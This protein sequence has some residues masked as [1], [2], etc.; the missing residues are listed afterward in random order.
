MIP[1]TPRGIRIL[2]TRSPFGLLLIEVTSPTGSGSPA[3]SLRL[4]AIPS[5]TLS[6]MV[7]RSTIAADRPCASAPSRSLLFA[8]LMRSPP[9]RSPS[10]I[11]RRALSLTL[12]PR[13]ASSSE[14]ERAD[15]ATFKTVDSIDIVDTFPVIKLIRSVVEGFSPRKGRTLK[16]S[17]TCLMHHLGLNLTS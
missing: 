9:L 11:R 13:D 12:E 3:T 4:S 14:A 1:M 17:T 5:S 7:R 2:P 6:L 15:L 8:S 10:A 16:S